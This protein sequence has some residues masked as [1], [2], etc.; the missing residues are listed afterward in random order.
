MKKILYTLLLILLVSFVCDDAMAQ[1]VQVKINTPGGSAIQNLVDQITGVTRTINEKSKEMLKFADLLI[2]SSLY[3]EAAKIKFEVW[4]VNLFEISLISI[5]LYLSGIILY[6]LAFFILLISSFYMFDVAL[7]LSVTFTLLPIA[8]ALWPFSWTKGKLS[9]VI[10]NVTYYT[11][12]F[13]F[14]PLGILIGVEMVYSVIEDALN[15][16][17][18]K[19]LYAKDNSEKLEEVFTIIDIPFLK[20]VLCYIMAIKI[21]PLMA[22]DFCTHFFGSALIGTPMADNIKKAM[23]KTAQ[24]T[25]G[26]AG[27]YAKDVAK[28]QTGKTIQNIGNKMGNGLL[29]RAI[30]GYGKNMAKTRKRG[31]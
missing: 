23:N 13:I 31:G 6:I 1:F 14:L 26:R 21:I 30:A 4:G 29:S 11:G 24:H 5:K 10:K 18:L 15:I 7:N 3:G 16:P 8:L 2:C 17:D 19:D 12:L 25:V 20:L 22:D 28:H 27:K 9:I